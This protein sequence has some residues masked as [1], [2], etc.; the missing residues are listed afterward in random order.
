MLVA[1]C[2]RRR[3]VGAHDAGLEAARRA[4]VRPAAEQERDRL[5]PSQGELLADRRLEPLAAPH[6]AV[7]DRRVGYLDLEHREG[8]AVAGV[9]VLGGQGLRQLVHRAREVGADLGGAERRGDLVEQP[10]IVD[11]PEAVS[12][13]GSWPRP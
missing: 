12:E 13:S 5:G 7:Q 1:E 3:R 10:G 9:A 11:R 8:V 4:A 6:R 2:D